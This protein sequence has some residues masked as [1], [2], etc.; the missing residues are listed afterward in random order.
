MEWFGKCFFIEVVGM[1]VYY[2]IMIEEVKVILVGVN[3]VK[4][5]GNF[6]GI[7]E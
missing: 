2:C 1:D 3:G 7:I 6:D 5:I 4:L